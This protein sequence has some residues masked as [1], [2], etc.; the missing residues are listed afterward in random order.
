MAEIKV[1]WRRT[2]QI[3]PYETETIELGMTDTLPVNG[4]AHER[5]VT[6]ANTERVL[7]LELTRIGDRIMA[8]RLAKQDAA[9][10]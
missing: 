2:W 3:K 7:L 6:V 5:G 10:R 9:P 1:S 4:N 8:E